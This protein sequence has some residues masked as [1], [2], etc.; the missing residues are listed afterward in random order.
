MEKM[1][2]ELI[3]S[4]TLSQ[5]VKLGRLFLAKIAKAAGNMSVNN[6]IC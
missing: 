2:G 5:N 1:W 6:D 4:I 3:F